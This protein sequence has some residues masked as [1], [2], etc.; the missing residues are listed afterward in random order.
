MKQLVILLGTIIL[1]S[2][3]FQMMAG[4]GP[5]SLKSAA[6]SLMRQNICRYAEGVVS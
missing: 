2:L 1:G 3:I 4:D 5:D 6:S